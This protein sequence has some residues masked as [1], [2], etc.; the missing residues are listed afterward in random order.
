MTSWLVRLPKPLGVFA[1]TDLLGRRILEACLRARIEVPDTIAVVG[2]DNDE[3]LCEL[4]APPLSSV[5]ANHYGVGYEAAGLLARL[6]R[7]GSPPTSRVLI[8]PAELVV[9][10]SSERWAVSD[11]EVA[12]AL[13]LIHAGPDDALRTAL[14]V[15]DVVRQ[16]PL[17]RRTLERRF[18][19]VVGHSIYDE[20]LR[21]RVNRA[22]HLLSA[23]TWPI[24]RIALETG[25]SYPEHLA[26]VFKTRVGRS[27]TQYRRSIRHG[28]AP[29][30]QVDRRAPRR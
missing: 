15:E 29:G 12:R 30:Q 19:Q 3:T 23:T 24:K 21:A 28:D 22:Q 6:M 2:V 14:H 18:H 13:G 27:P 25:F 11:P 10:A 17:S 26:A 4:A 7:G 16:V 1:S 8:Q 5:D 9:R 20:I